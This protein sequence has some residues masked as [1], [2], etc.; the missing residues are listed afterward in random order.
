VDGVP[1]NEISRLDWLGM[2]TVAGQDVE[3]VE[4]TIAENIRMARNKA[5]AP[6][7]AGAGEVAGLAQM[8]AGLPEGYDTWI[9]Q[10]GL[11][12]SG[13]QRQ[14]IGLARAVIRHPQLLILDEATSELDFDLEKQVR[15]A[16]CRR[17]SDRTI[18]LITHRL[19]TLSSVDHVIC[20]ENGQVR[21]EGR[22]S[23][24][25]PGTADGPARNKAIRAI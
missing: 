4:G 15:A 24:V 13:G 14:R 5:T 6:E 1:L 16:I 11:N 9:G 25:L 17:F 18:L 3:L 19:E 2:L 21:G 7:I 20:I 22:A 10:E 8:V 23:D 12:L